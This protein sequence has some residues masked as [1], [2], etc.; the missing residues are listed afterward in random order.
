M[1]ADYVAAVLAD[2]PQAFW[3][4]QELSGFP[5]DSSGHG[6]HMDT[7]GTAGGPITYQVAGPRSSGAINLNG[8]MLA[9][10]AGPVVTATDNISLEVWINTF[11]EGNL[12]L[13]VVHLGALTG[14]SDGNVLG[15]NGWGL[16]STNL[17]HPVVRTLSGGALSTSTALTTAYTAGAAS[18]LV[19]PSFWRQY[20]VVRRSGTWEVWVDGVQDTSLGSFTATPGSPTGTSVYV[21]HSSATQGQ[22]LSVAYLSLW[23]LALSGT[24]IA[25]HYAAM[26]RWPDTQPIRD[27]FP[28]E[29]EAGAFTTQ[30]GNGL[31]PDVPPHD[32][33]YPE[34]SWLGIGGAVQYPAQGKT[35]L[36]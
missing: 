7:Q 19:T 12:F 4:M 20:V 3:Q 6:N 18:T 27:D 10:A 28:T 33:D 2:L 5:Q 25:A 9:R 29:A 35:R 23:N 11:S 34:L 24:R 15:N 8:S 36:V 13:P 1:Y 21:G 17:L 26:Y 31:V 32:A 16:H 22:T 14:A 30:G